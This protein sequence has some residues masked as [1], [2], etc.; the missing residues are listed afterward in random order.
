MR[1]ADLPDVQRIAGEVH[2]AHPEGPDVFAERLRLYPQGCFVL[3]GASGPAGYLVSHPWRADDAPAL[4]RRIVALP[5]DASTFYLHDLALLP[6]ARGSGAGSGIVREILRHA[7]DKGYPSAAL[8]AVSGSEAFWTAQGF[9][10]QPD[11]ARKCASYGPGAMFMR[12]R[13]G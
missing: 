2:P 6:H 7:A 10:A 3:Q 9:D 1:Q 4:D 13:L 11:M 5:A 12:R 8:I